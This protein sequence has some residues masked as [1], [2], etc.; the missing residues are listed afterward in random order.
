[1]HFIIELFRQTTTSAPRRPIINKDHGVGPNPRQ[2]SYGSTAYHLIE[3]GPFGVTGPVKLVCD[4]RGRFIPLDPADL[5]LVCQPPR[6]CSDGP[7]PRR[8]RASERIANGLL[9]LYT[10]V[11]QTSP[12]IEA[13]V[14]ELSFDPALQSELGNA[15]RRAVT[16]SYRQLTPLNSFTALR[17]L[18]ACTKI[19]YRQPPMSDRSERVG[20]LW[21]DNAGIVRA[22][23]LIWTDNTPEQRT[24]HLV[25]IGA[26][27]FT[28]DIA[29]ILDGAF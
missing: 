14:R 10:K 8:P 22:R 7:H 2:E 17:A 28:G 27:R 20:L 15:W 18:E 5:D 25:Q 23:G 19:V 3:R 26:H 11:A 6:Y 29:N 24:H 9:E 12:E 13:R 16:E 1:M 21:I 4:H